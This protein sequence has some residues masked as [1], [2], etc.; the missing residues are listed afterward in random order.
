M[1]SARSSWAW[2]RQAAR[3]GHW[4]TM[5]IARPRARGTAAPAAWRATRGGRIVI[6]ITELP[7]DIDDVGAG[8]DHLL[9]GLVEER[10]GG[11]QPHRI[12]RIGAPA[13]LTQPAL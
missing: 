5:R 2:R 11:V 1:C 10:R 9:A 8:Q 3:A 12:A 13:A 4:P 6:G 7:D